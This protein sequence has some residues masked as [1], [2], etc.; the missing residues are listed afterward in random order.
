MCDTLCAL[1]ATRTL[2]AKNS[3]RPPTEVQLVAPMLAGGRR[4][5]PHPVSGNRRRR[6]LCHTARRPSWLW[7]AEHGVNEYGVAIG[8]EKVYTTLDAQ[9]APAALIGMD[10]VRLGLERATNADEALEVITG[11]SPATGRGR[12]GHVRRGLLLV[13]PHRGPDRRL[14]ARDIG[15][16]LG[17]EAGRGQCGHLEPPRHPRRL[18]PVIARRRTGRGLRHMARSRSADGIADSRLQASCAVL[19]TSSAEELGARDLAAH[20]R[21]HGSGPWG[22]PGSGDAPVPRRRSCWS[23]GRGCRCAC[24]STTT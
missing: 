11:C 7:G 22:A 3:D 4:D 1:G 15:R 24:T 10:L 21:D 14:G 20:L 2:F 5:D 19:G 18:D 12:S 16:F 6:R 23:T 17:G 8:N 9:S 13:V